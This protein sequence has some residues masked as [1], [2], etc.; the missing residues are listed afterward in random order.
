MAVKNVEAKNHKKKI[1]MDAYAQKLA[2]AGRLEDD[3]IA[4]ATKS[5][6]LVTVIDAPALASAL[7]VRE[8]ISALDSSDR[9]TLRSRL[10]AFTMTNASSTPIPKSIKGRRECTGP[11]KSPNADEIPKPAPILNPTVTSAARL[12]VHRLPGPGIN[13]PRL[14]VDVF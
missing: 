7:P 2:K 11:K 14:A 10:N 3:E 5:V 9:F 4:K 8:V 6:K 12:M 13:L 1:P